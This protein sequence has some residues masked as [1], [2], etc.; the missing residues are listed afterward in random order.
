MGRVWGAILIGAGA[1]LWYY[2]GT[3]GNGYIVNL[4]LGSM[5][6]GLVL[7]ALPSSGHVEKDALYMS[8]GS[9]PGFVENMRR[10]AGLKGPPIVIPPYENLPTGGIFLPESENPS[11]NLGRMSSKTTFVTGSRNEAGIL[12]TPPPG[13]GIIE[14]TLENVGE[15]QGSAGYAASAVSSVLSAFGLSSAK[16]FENGGE[17]ELFVKPLCGDY[18][19]D[20]AVSAMLLSVAMG[21]NEL[22]K[23]NS[24]E[25][26]RDHLKITL[27]PMGGVERWL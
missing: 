24:I 14:Y 27:E 21:K 26:V 9:F 1:V 13:W 3:G 15:L 4:G 23:V 17:I 2:G 7:A 12:L 8:C 18:V 22:L 6:L 20:P 16:V 10:D 25:K 5:I 11:P 19:S